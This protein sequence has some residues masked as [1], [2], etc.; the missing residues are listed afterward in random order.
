MHAGRLGDPGYSGG[1][2]RF[3][4]CDIIGDYLSIE[5][6]GAAIDRKYPDPIPDLDQPRR[7]RK[8]KEADA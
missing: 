2:I 4:E 1:A 8:R 6:I 7:K 3:H 5:D